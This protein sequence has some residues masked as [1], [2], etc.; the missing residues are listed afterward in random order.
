MQVFN[1]DAIAQAFAETH[2]AGGEIT[3]AMAR[4][5]VKIHANV[6]KKPISNQLRLLYADG[7][8]TGELAA[9]Y[10]LAHMIRRNKALEAPK[11]GVVNW[12]TWKPGNRAAAA[13]LAPQGGLESL[14]ASRRIQITDD[15][16]NT[17]LNQIGTLLSQALAK[18]KTPK[19]VSILIDDLI[20]DPEKAL[21]IAQTEMS[22][23]VSIAQRDLYE[24]SGVE[25]VEWLVA[26]GC[27]EC[28]QNADASPIGIGDTFPTGDAE[29]PAHPNCMCDLAPYISPQQD[30]QLAVMPDLTKF[31]PSEV[32][33]ERAKSRLK[34]LPNPAEY[35]ADLNPDKLVQSAWET[36]PVITVNPNIWDNAELALVQF[37]N[38]IGT[39]L[40]L[41]RKKLK[42]HIESMGQATT[43]FRAFALV[44]ERD[45]KQIIIDGHHRLMA[46]WLLGMTEAPV[47]LAKE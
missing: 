21:S 23:A 45:G 20:D 9:K 44:V 24:T 22:R 26:V 36:I 34:I 25:M 31:V 28:Q 29:P 18:G 35:P 7:Y 3:P 19:E 8:V 40:Y 42:E 16:V 27:E 15:V 46:M 37:E 32:E 43:P 39:D 2:P 14:L 6:N 33:V 1:A 30:V 10:R 41:R 17:K 12:E 5:W 38:L 47:W 4:D 11:V 13:L